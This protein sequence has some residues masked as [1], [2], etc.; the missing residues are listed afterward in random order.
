MRLYNEKRGVSQVDWAISLGIFI[1]YLAWF[2]VFVRPQFEVEESPA[3]LLDSTKERLLEQIEWSVEKSPLFVVSNLT[4]EKEGVIVDFPYSLS[5][6]AFSNNS[7]FTLDEGRLLFLADLTEGANLF[8]IVSSSKN[9]SLPSIIEDI[10]STKSYTTTANFRADFSSGLLGEIY[11][12]NES[13][14]D[15]FELYVNGIAIDRT[16]NS[17]VNSSILGGYKIYTENV[18]HKCYVLAENTKVYCFVELG[19]E[20]PHDMTIKADLVEFSNYYGNNL[21]AGSIDDSTC[22]SFTGDYIDFYN[23]NDGLSFIFDKDAD[24]GFC[25]DGGLSFSAT[26]RLNRNVSYM[27]VAHNGSYSRTLDYKLPYYGYEWGI[28]EEVK[29][30]DAEKAQELA[31]LSYF[32]LKQ[33][34]GYPIAQELK[35]YFE[36]EE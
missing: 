35:I 23:S 28:K 29:G 4:G 7:Y 2:F 8:W 9:Y 1:L 19:K 26:I 18:E 22:E 30:I 15:S 16:D 24:I 33:L 6:F 20:K 31:N 25:Y 14:L 11:F 27:I 32:E 17:F 21:Y 10:T 12:N 34:L 3:Q 36:E 13:K 5:S